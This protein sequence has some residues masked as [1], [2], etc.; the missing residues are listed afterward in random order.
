MGS[1][2]F[3]KLNLT[4]PICRK[5]NKSSLIIKITLMKAFNREYSQ[6]KIKKDSFETN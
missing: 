4:N 1:N 2:C 6:M 5:C 3:S